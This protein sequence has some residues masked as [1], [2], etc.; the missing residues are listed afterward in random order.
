MC[1]IGFCAK[2]ELSVCAIVKNESR[3]L[4]EWIE[5][6]RLI[7]VS[8]FYLYDTA[9]VDFPK[10]ILRKYISE[11]LV[12]LVPWPD[13]S[14]TLG[15]KE[16][17]IW[18]L[19]IQ[20]IA[21]QHAI[22]LKQ[23]ETKWLIILDVDEFLIPTGGDIQAVLKEYDKFPGMLIQSDYFD[24]SFKNELPKNKLVIQSFE[25]IEPPIQN[26]Q[27]SVEKTIFNPK[28]IQQFSWPPFRCIFKNEDKPIAIPKTKLKINRYVNRNGK[29]IFSHKKGKMRVDPYT[30]EDEIKKMLDVGFEIED[31]TMERFVPEV[32]EKMGY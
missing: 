4:K 27:K 11:K 9:S 10:R 2:Y 21:Y 28:R 8:H 13:V 20:T 3:Y 1:S 19:G 22:Q 24:A 17:H 6:H 15:E 5:Y 25:M 23:K 32:L 30:S 12:T 7:G 18:S 26:I 16:T 29:H 31:S 14:Q